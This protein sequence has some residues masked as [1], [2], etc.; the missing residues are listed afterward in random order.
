MSDTFYDLVVFFGRHPFWVSSDP[1]ILHASR[2][3]RHGPFLLASNHVSPI[4][5]AVLMR[6]TRRRLDFVSIT[7]V[8]AN[9]WV[10]WFYGNM[11][12]F[13]LDR[14]RT[15][16]KTVRIILDRLQ[17]GRVVAM[18]PEGRIRKEADSVVHGAPFRPGVARIARLAGVKIM[19]VVCWGTT[20]YAKPANWI[21]LR[22]TRYGINY[23]EPFDVRDE[24][25]AERKLAEAWRN[26]YAELREAMDAR[27]PSRSL[28]PLLRGEG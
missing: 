1:V 27:C 17:R 24:A 19:P 15:D 22:Q 21:P 28:S 3:P 10:G 11:N 12:A 20:R 18:F 16:P 9:P 26:L 7:E 13:P 6:S 8:F 14:S 2:V 4:D 5:V 25:D 23:G